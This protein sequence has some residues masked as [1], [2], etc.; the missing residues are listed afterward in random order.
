MEI[1]V[2][3]KQRVGFQFAKHPPQLLLN[4][5]HGVEKVA[6]LVFVFVGYMFRVISIQ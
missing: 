1:L 4:P 5:V 2:D 3:G 6:D